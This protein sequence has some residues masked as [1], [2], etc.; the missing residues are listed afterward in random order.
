MN[1]LLLLLLST[2]LLNF[3]GCGEEEDTTP[4]PQH[5]DNSL[6]E[7]LTLINMDNITHKVTLSPKKLTFHDIDQPIVLINIYNNL[8]PETAY[9]LK[10]LSSL[11]QKNPKDIFA[12]SLLIGDTINT[13]TLQTFIKKNNILHYVSN[14]IE[15]H[16]FTNILK[17]SL[18]LNLDMSLP[19]TVLYTDGEYTIHY[20]NA[21]PIEMIRYD[22]QQALK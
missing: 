11:Q 13:A 3:S 1:V 14:D 5:V 10:A 20:N 18:F 16:T 19:L 15:N 2:L 21:I 17:E 4:A 12:V 6:M 22:I 7:T 8:S 9:Q